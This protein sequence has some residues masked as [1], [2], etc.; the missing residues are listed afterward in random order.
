MA[1]QIVGINTK[2]NERKIEL[3]LKK[4]RFSGFHSVKTVIHRDN[5]EEF[6]LFGG[7]TH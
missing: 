5:F 1:L 7:E 6:L 3:I 2:L 4:C